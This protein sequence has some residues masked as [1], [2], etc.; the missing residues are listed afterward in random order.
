MLLDYP[1]TTLKQNFKGMVGL[2]KDENILNVQNKIIQ[3]EKVAGRKPGSVTL[4]AVSKTKPADMVIAAV[5]KGLLNFGE[6]YVQE[7][8]K[9]VE[10]VKSV[11]GSEG[12]KVQWHLIGGLQTNKSKLVIGKFNTIQSVDRFEL[13]KALDARAKEA[14]LIQNILFQVKLGDEPTK[15]GVEEKAVEVLIEKCLELKNLRLEGLMTLPPMDVEAEMSRKY[16]SQLRELMNRV[17]NIIPAEQGSFSQ[18]SM[19]TTH[20]FTV[21]IEEGATMVRVGTA[22]FGAREKL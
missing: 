12:S 3:A 2:L 11:L 19:G 18:L 21:A 22:L 9:K 17:K 1:S 14:G 10:K 15:G 8:V 7:A 4:I 6:N 20:D 5:Q 16:F 13:A